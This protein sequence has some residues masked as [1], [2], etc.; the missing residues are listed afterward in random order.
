MRYE[1]QRFNEELF[2]R[3]PPDKGS[4]DDLDS[5]SAPIPGQSLTM[6]PGTQAFEKPWVYTDPDECLIF[7]MER[8]EQ[9]RQVKEEHLRV[10]AA[11]TP[12]EYVVNTIAFAG[13]TEGLWSPDVAELIKPG[14]A[15]YFILQAQEEDIPIVLFNPEPKREGILTDADVVESMKTLNPDAHQVLSER[16]QGARMSPKL[17]GFLNDLQAEQGGEVIDVE[18]EQVPEEIL[19]EGMI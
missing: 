19:K 13:F 12:V 3:A 1:P 17:E 18:G 16:A 15:L 9:D 5:F 14:L 10:L 2:D 4:I 6:E 11:G 7:L 8:M